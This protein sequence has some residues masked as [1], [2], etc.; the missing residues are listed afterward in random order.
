[1]LRD[2]AIKQKYKKANRKKKDRVL[3]QKQ[4][5]EKMGVLPE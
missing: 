5:L 1:M 3:K 2:A 4:K